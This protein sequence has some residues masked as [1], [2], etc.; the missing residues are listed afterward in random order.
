MSKLLPIKI[1]VG[2]ESTPN[3]IIRL[4]ADYGLEVT[5]EQAE[6]LRRIIGD[7]WCSRL[8]DGALRDSLANHIEVDWT[9]CRDWQSKMLRRLDRAFT[10]HPANG[11]RSIDEFWGG[12]MRVVTCGLD[13]HPDWFDCPCEC[14]ACEAKRIANYP[15]RQ[16]SWRDVFDM[17]TV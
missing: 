15:P 3:R 16:E 2:S 12:W 13:R 10:D 1:I 6:Q 5:T 9:E 11:D 8:N 14:R 7:D 4:L 17:S